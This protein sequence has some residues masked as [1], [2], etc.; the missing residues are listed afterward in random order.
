MTHKWVV[1]GSC[2]LAWACIAEPVSAGWGSW[3]GSYGSHGSQGGSN[4]SWGSTGEYASSGCWGSS[5]GT[6]SSYGSQGGPIRQ[7]FRRIHARRA[8]R[9]SYYG[10]SWGGSHGSHG[11][12]GGSY[13]S[14]GSWGGSYG[15]SGGSYTIID[16]CDAAVI[17][18]GPAGSMQTEPTPP[19]DT[20]QP[21]DQS[22]PEQGFREP[23]ESSSGQAPTDEGVGQAVL[24]VQ[25]P[26]DATLIVNGHRTRSTGEARR[27][28][29]Q[30]LKR[31]RRYRY[32]VQALLHRD[33]QQRSSSKTVELRADQVAHLS[34]D[35]GSTTSKAEPVETALT[36]RVPE[37]A[38]VRLSG[39][40]TRSTGPVRRF[41]TDEITSGAQW[42]DYLVEVTVERDGRRVTQKRQVNLRGG[43][44]VELG[45]DF[46]SPETSVASR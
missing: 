8:T 42:A 23:G 6:F 40:P 16:D 20:Q 33:G 24:D 10:G 2:L 18:G 30:G 19:S 43:D 17:E 21:Q 46:P 34:F 44:Q 41:A 31:N 28:V 12:W 36:L 26:E 29:S 27:F 14:H 35:F 22:G 37:D 39:K 15:S 38:E 32:T 7:F 45:F 1:L 3:G 9:V 4:G 25:V 13:G 11:S 5:S